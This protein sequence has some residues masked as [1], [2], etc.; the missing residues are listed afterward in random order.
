MPIMNRRRFLAAAAASAA[1]PAFG[2]TPAPGQPD[3]IVI[4][5]G[6]AGIAAARRIAGAGRRALVLEASDRIGGRC[7]TDTRTFGVPF[8][9][10]AH[11]IHIPDINPLAK[12]TP[13]T[14]L[15]INS[16]PPG[17]KVRIGRRSAREGETEDYLAAL[18][19]A[20]RAIGDAARKADIPCSRALPTKELQDWRSSVEFV[21][22]PYARGRDLSEVSAV[23]FAR[24]ADRDSEAF[25]RQGLGT[26][27]VKLAEGLT[28]QL[29]TPVR[30]IEAWGRGVEV[31]TSR[32]RLTARGAIFTVSSA[33]LAANKIRFEPDLPK[34]Y[35]DA[36]NALKL[37][38]FDH[39]ALELPGNPLGL[40]SDDLVFEKAESERTGAL[41]ANVA[42]STL[43]V[44]GVGGKFGRDLAAQGEAAMVAFAQDWLT[45]LYGADI[46]KA[47]RRT[48]TTRWSDEPWVMG[49]MSS[50]SPGGQGARR[51]LMEPFRERIWFAGEAVHETLPGTVGGAWES[52]ER[53]AEAAMR[54]FGMVVEPRP[55]PRRAP[56]R[57]R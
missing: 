25:C 1:G 2:A 44:V 10:G 17:L 39:I 56:S 53:A 5:A 23:D 43:C 15:Q 51:V 6:A 29:S 32:G 49:A 50:A 34:R 55:E 13:G 31:V 27:V 30:G 20:S 48:S 45:G 35:I 19:R 41:L 14:G 16:T 33:V 3:F 18:V 12:L 28:V 38:S 36:V 21:L 57:R 8:D 22:G 7:F 42:G 40:Q 37:G 46:K 47:V 24:S 54:K 52:G 9:R 11:W 4:G 26:L